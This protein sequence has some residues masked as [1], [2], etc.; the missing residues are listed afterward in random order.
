MPPRTAVS[1]SSSEDEDF[2]RFESVA[3]SSAQL[4]QQAKASEKVPGLNWA[5]KQPTC[6]VRNGTA[7]G[8]LLL[9]LQ[10]LVVSQPPLALQT[11]L[12]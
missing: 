3:V 11:L 1:D 10:V 6:P 5:C 4:E 2:S 7:P 12:C 9:F 8:L